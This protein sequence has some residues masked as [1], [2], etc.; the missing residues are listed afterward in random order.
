M[1]WRRDAERELRWWQRW[2]ANGP[3]VRRRSLSAEDL[4]LYQAVLEAP[5]LGPGIGPIFFVCPEALSD[6][7]EA[8]DAKP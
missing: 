4:L 6:W 7:S 1:S 5:L 8:D 3:V 2:F